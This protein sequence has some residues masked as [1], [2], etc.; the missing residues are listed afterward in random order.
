MHMSK[1][2]TVKIGIESGTAL[3]LKRASIDFVNVHGCNLYGQLGCL[4]LRRD[5]AGKH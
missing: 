4:G 1:E 2:S 3:V 5:E